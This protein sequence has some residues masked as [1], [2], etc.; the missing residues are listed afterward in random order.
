MIII[1]ILIMMMMFRVM[2]ETCLDR[3]DS[4]TVKINYY[5]REFRKLTLEVIS[6]KSTGIG[7]LE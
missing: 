7:D 1:K 4:M 6:K 2:L 5:S 3:I